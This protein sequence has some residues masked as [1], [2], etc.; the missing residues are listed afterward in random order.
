MQYLLGEPLRNTKYEIR[1][2]GL[3]YLLILHGVQVLEHAESG[4]EVWV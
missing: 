4:G 3:S 2:L 1:I